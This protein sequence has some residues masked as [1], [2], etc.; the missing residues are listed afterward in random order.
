MLPVP[1][2]G[3]VAVD[4]QLREQKLRQATRAFEGLFLTQ[5]IK[6]MRATV[7]SPD[8]DRM[9]GK[10]VLGGY[11]DMELGRVLAERR[12]TGLAE[13][14]YEAVKPRGAEPTRPGAVK[15]TLGPPS[16]RPLAPTYS[17]SVPRYEPIVQQAARRHGLSPQLIRAVITVESAGDPRARSP[18]QAKGLMQLTDSTAGMLGVTDVWD[19]QQNIDAGARYL[20]RLLD[21]FDGNLE[22]ALAAYNAGPTTVQRYGGTPPYP[23]TRA[24]VKRVLEHYRPSAKEASRV[25]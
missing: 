3:P 16:P 7:S 5:L 10:S 21:R 1:L 8:G 12:G 4:P 25:R 22:H 6:V 24:Y 14:L 20:R 18:R 11:A 2:T 17:A 23:E 13:M 15:R 9:A 19:P